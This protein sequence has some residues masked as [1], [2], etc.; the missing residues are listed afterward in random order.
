MKAKH[1]I[2][3][4]EDQVIFKIKMSR[5]SSKITIERAVKGML[6]RLKKN[7]GDNATIKDL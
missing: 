3:N 2:S 1:Y 5:L 7:K 4:Q 6:S